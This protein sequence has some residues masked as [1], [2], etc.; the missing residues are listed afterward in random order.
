MKVHGLPSSLPAAASTTGLLLWA[1][2]L[3]LSSSS[4]PGVQAGPITSCGLQSACLKWE[5]TKLASTTCSNLGTCPVRV[6]MI[7]D[8]A[9]QGCVKGSADT[10]SHACDNANA[11]GCVRS[12]VWSSS[13]DGDSGAT[14]IAPGSESRCPNIANGYRMC[15]IGKKNDILYFT[16][17]VARCT[18]R[19]RPTTRCIPVALLLELRCASPDPLP[20]PS[21]NCAARTE[22]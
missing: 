2:A 22:G 18:L 8:L 16:V 14:C 7:F 11:D 13:V 17:Y 20:P 3:L 19:A 5:V 1:L 4:L 12:Q 21:S 10:V 9:A 15:Q 6:C